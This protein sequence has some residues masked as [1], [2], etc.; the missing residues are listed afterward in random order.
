MI[1]I[2]P[3][4]TFMHFHNHI[5]NNCHDLQLDVKFRTTFLY[6]YGE[7]HTLII[8]IHNWYTDSYLC[9]TIHYSMQYMNRV[10]ESIML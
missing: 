7:I 6:W 4:I 1:S 8:E 9:I 2:M 5:V 10:L 3:P